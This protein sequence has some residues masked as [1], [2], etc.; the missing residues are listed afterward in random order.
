MIYGMDLFSGYGGITIALSEWVRPIV[1]C[2][3]ERYAQ[4]IL[5]SRMAEGL[6]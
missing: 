2:E 3:K 5:L 1:Y 6:L 4:A